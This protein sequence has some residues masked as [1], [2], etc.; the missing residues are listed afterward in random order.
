MRLA[1]GGS[2]VMCWNS[3]RARCTVSC[4]AHPEGWWEA[5]RYFAAVIECDLRCGDPVRFCV[6]LDVNVPRSSHEKVLR[7]VAQDLNEVAALMPAETLRLISENMILWLS[8]TCSR[9]GAETHWVEK[10]FVAQEPVFPPRPF[11][12]EVNDWEDYT[13]SDLSRHGVL[14]HEF[15]HIY[16]AILGREHPLFHVLYEKA[17]EKDIYPAETYGLQNKEEFFASLSVPLWGGLNDYFPKTLPELEKFDPDS[18]ARIIEIW[19]IKSGSSQNER[20]GNKR[21]N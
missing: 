4:T 15:S 20:N 10:S 2:S 18:L 11:A 12:V 19:S 9:K 1:V 3:R 6:L 17:L 7:I 5:G 16:H 13:N 21:F 8:L 14:L